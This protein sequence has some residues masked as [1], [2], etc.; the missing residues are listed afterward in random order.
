MAASEALPTLKN[1]YVPDYGK[2]SPEQHKVR[3]NILPHATGAFAV[4][5]S[6]GK[7]YRP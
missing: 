4:N 5:R 1:L 7:E 6:F 3:Q 2:P